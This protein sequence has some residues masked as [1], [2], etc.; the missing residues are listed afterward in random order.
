MNAA[1]QIINH[2]PWWVY[3]LFVYLIFISYRATKTK[4]VSLK[5]LV[6]IPIIFVFIALHTLLTL[7]TPSIE[8]ILVAFITALI[9]GIFGWLHIRSLNIKFDKRRALLQIPGS[10][11]T[12]ALILIVCIT[13]FMFS[14]E[15]ALDPKI[16]NDTPFEISLLAVTSFCAGLFLGRFAC[17]IYRM[18]VEETTDLRNNE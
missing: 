3:L 8:T 7:V 11:L 17:Y 9:G 2:T 4:I 15:L 1:W 13:K 6:L 12:M 16:V 10:W 14:Y 5:R 18:Q